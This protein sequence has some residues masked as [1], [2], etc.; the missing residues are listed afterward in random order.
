MVHRRPD[1]NVLVIDK[2]ASIP[3]HPCG[4]FLLNSVTHIVA[5]ETGI[6]TLHVV[7]RLDR[8]TSGLL[9]LATDSQV[10]LY[11]LESI[12]L[13]FSRHHT[14][15]SPYFPS[16]CSH[17][18]LCLFQAAERISSQLRARTL[19]KHYL[20]RVR[21]RFPSTMEEARQSAAA[22]AQT[23]ILGGGNGRSGTDQRFIERSEL[24]GK[25][26]DM[27]DEAEESTS[28]SSIPANDSSSKNT[29]ANSGTEESATDSEASSV[30][31]IPP[32]LGSWG[33]TW[34]VNEAVVMWDGVG[35]RTLRNA[36]QNMLLADTDDVAISATSGNSEDS[37]NGNSGE[38]VMSMP[39]EIVVDR[40]VAKTDLRYGLFGIGPAE[41]HSNAK[42]NQ[43]NY[44]PEGKAALTCF[45]R[46]SYDPVTDTS[47]VHCMPRTGRTH[48]LRVHLMHLGHPIANDERYGGMRLPEWSVVKRECALAAGKSLDSENSVVD[49]PNDAN[50]ERRAVLWRQARDS[51]CVFCAD[52]NAGLWSDRFH[53]LKPESAD[54]ENTPISEE[55]KKSETSEPGIED[56]RLELSGSITSGAHGSSSQGL[57]GVKFSERCCNSGNASQHQDWVDG[58]PMRDGKIAMDVYPDK[59]VCCFRCFM[60]YIHLTIW[61]SDTY[62]SYYFVPFHVSSHHHDAFLYLFPNSVDIDPEREVIWLHALKYEAPDWTFS[63]PAPVWA[64]DRTLTVPNMYYPP[65]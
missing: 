2:P 48:Q 51:T 60:R 35:A 30:G 54:S 19:R 18:D 7:H 45:R 20:A 34:G 37:E 5:K 1:L 43:S 4:K 21:G 12:S 28:A 26:I 49:I 16:I 65:V 47:L 6:R 27:E 3:V 39:C 61:V 25:D 10:R 53:F 52:V 24:S 23:G 59:Y 58:L 38:D 56:G 14:H 40:P 15:L 55:M 32:L 9:M 57:V 46:I 11:L 8:A 13:P 29:V 22:A 44:G 50:E 64:E 62:F 36:A 31:L 33:E 63:V 17:H 42:Y 41:R